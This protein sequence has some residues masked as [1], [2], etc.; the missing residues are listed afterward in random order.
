MKLFDLLCAG[1]LFLLAVAA[2]LF[3]PTA[4]A[5][6][7]WIYGTDLALLFAAMLNLLRLQNGYV[8][9]GL[10]MFC[11]TSNI[12]MREKRRIEFDERWFDYSSP[13]VPEK[14]EHSVARRG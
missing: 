7:I 2:S 14:S 12:A 11:V 1:K 4:Y 8:M 3:I 9:R 13:E 6:R 5:G 10:K